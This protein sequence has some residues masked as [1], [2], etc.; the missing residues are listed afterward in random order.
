[1]DVVRYL[2]LFIIITT[3]G[4]L[5]D[6]YKTKYFG[7]DDY[8]KEELVR[9]YLINESK[10]G[11]PIMWI[12]LDYV[13]NSR[14][15][16]SFYSRNSMNLNRPYIECCVETIMKYCGESF[17]ICLIDDESFSNLLP[18]WTTQMNLLSTPLKEHMRIKGTLSLLYEYGGL[19]MPNSMVMLKNIKSLYNDSLQNNDCF[20]VEMVNTTSTNNTLKF[21]PSYKFMGAKQRSVGVKNLI[22]FV[23][24]L[25][26]RDHTSE[27]DFKASINRYLLK[28]CMENKI[29]LV[30]GNYIGIKKEN[31]KPVLLDDLMSDK[32]IHL[33]DG[34]YGLYISDD[35]LVRSKY[36]WFTRQSKE[37]I[38]GNDNNI[39]K[40]M[41]VAYGK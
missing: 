17:N 35:I 1:M 37:Q 2:S 39:A 28:C 26:L 13:V 33:Y 5:Y 7:L 11:K 22:K 19:L 27:M 21:I 41:L 34:M 15:W 14:H 31:S 40:Y 12:H 10:K 18:D 3:I 20:T 8:D 32:Y 24:D 36:E 6:K 4:I 9:K 25:I 38:F 16:Q 23:D 30:S 29:H